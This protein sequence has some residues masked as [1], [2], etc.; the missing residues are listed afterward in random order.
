MLQPRIFFWRTSLAAFFLALWYLCKRWRP[1]QGFKQERKGKFCAETL[2]D[3][4]QWN[5]NTS[6]IIVRLNLCKYYMIIVIIVS[7]S[8]FVSSVFIN[9]CRV[10]NQRINLNLN[11]TIS[12]CITSFWYNTDHHTWTGDFTKFSHA[13]F[14]V[15]QDN[16]LNLSITR[17]PRI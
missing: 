11:H 8:W 7:Q 3:K 14:Q 5:A 13:V 2:H 10:I 1:N 6:I 16:S 12:E 15:T 9:H 4:Q 17:W